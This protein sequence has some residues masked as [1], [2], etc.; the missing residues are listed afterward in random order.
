MSLKTQ[1]RSLTALLRYEVNPDFTREEIT[2]RNGTADAVT[3][4][5]PVGYPLKYVSGKY[6]LAL[7]G[8]EG[9]VDALL[10]ATEDFDAVAATTDFAGKQLAIVRGP[11][12]VSKAGIKTVDVAGD[13]FNV[14][15][16]IATLAALQIQV[17]SEPVK[18]Q[19]QTT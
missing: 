17:H 15:T 11:A 8:D 4:T 5:D 9:T 1:N 19:E 18:Q 13:A 7:A 16:I 6:L 12:I 14:T 2:L 10:L 3:L